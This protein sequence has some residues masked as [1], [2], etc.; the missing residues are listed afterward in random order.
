MEHRILVTLTLEYILQH[1]SW[2][3]SVVSNLKNGLIL[4]DHVRHYAKY[5]G[6][7]VRHRTS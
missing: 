4:A 6:R 3:E 7:T 5:I 2:S 1:F